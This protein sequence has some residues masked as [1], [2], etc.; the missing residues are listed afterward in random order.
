MKFSGVVSSV[1]QIESGRGAGNPARGLLPRRA[2]YFRSQSRTACH[3]GRALWCG[4]DGV[5]LR[6]HDRRILGLI[7]RA[8]SENRFSFVVSIELY[9]EHE[10]STIFCPVSPILMPGASRGSESLV[11]RSPAPK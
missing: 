1:D 10:E 4:D 7:S 3:A 11:S 9:V 8:R 6:V 2:V 5:T